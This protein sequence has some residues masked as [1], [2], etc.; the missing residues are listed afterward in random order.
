LQEQKR[1]TIISMYRIF[2][3]VTRSVPSA[4]PDQFSFVLPT[5]KFLSRI[6]INVEIVG[7]YF[8]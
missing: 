6:R 4:R 2:L 7:L 5:D 8:I 3:I 1:L